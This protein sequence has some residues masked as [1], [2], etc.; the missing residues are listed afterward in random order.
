MAGGWSRFALRFSEYYDSISPTSIWAPPRLRTREWMFIP[1]GGAPPDRH[2]SFLDKNSLHSYLRSRAPHSCF[3]STAYYQDPSQLKMAEKG[4]LGADLI[5]D[6]DGDHLPGVS[7]NDFPSMIEVIQGQAWR[8]WNEFLE[9]EFGFKEKHA[10]FTFSG[11]RGFHIH[12]RDPGILHLDSNARREIVNY[13]RGEGIDIQSTISDNSEWGR[14]AL[15]GIDSTL[16]KLAKI[17]SGESGKGALVDELH[18]ILTTRAN[19]P[20]VNLKSTSKASIIEL[21]ELADNA[22]KVARLKND[23]G[24]AVFGPKCTPIF[25]ELVKGDSSVVIGTAGETDE[26]VT[27]D[28]KRVIRWVGSL[29][30]KS[31]L[32]VTELPLERLDPDSRDSFDPLSEAVVFSGGAVKVRILA[33]DVTAEISGVRI[34]PRLGDEI[35]V[36]ESMAMFLCLKGWAEICK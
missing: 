31:G 36:Q 11:H 30:G 15:Q 25:W 3:H 2:R 29:H 12:V 1:W 18:G 27:V 33:E 4:W 17:S 22:D 9:P 14:R 7:D 8:L 35:E 20:Q 24:L 28:T 23:A 5:F 34:E 19:S 6:L 13:I 10:Q 26:V 21:A 32:R 16:D